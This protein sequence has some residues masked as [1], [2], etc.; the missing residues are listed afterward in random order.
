MARYR[1]TQEDNAR[2]RNT[3][4]KTRGAE[5]CGTAPNGTTVCLAAAK[6]PGMKCGFNKRI[7]LYACAKGKGGGRA[8]RRG[9]RGRRK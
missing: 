4:L 9:K 3:V 8:R 5:K 7:K 6:V 2:A 1:F